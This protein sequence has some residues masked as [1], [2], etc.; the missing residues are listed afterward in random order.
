MED[1]SLF[2]CLTDGDLDHVSGGMSCDR[3]IGLS[4]IYLTMSDLYNQMGLGGSA[5]SFSGQAL[6]L[7]QGA[8][9]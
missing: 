6:G 4:K 3:A 5:V 8:C 1:Q 7:L 9:T 2:E